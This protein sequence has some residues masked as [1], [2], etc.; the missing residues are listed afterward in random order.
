MPRQMMS[1]LISQK[2]RCK[3][4]I[5]VIILYGYFKTDLDNSYSVVLTMGTLVALKITN[6]LTCACVITVLEKHKTAFG[7]A[8]LYSVIEYS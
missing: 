5:V 2:K 3:D 7:R 8:I 4:N 1:R 6:S